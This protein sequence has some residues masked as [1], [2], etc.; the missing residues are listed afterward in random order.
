MFN[1]YK[2]VTLTLNTKG[3]EAQTIEAM[4]KEVDGEIVP[5]TPKEAKLKF[6]NKL[7]S[8]GGNPA[9]QNIK[10]ILLDDNGNPVNVDEL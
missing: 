9:T 6:L 4:T 5:C 10:C 2:L 7:S 8:V 1:N 3:G